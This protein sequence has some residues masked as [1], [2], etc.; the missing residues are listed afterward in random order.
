[1]NEILISYIFT[2]LPMIDITKARNDLIFL[3]FLRPSLPAQSTGGFI[4]AL[5]CGTMNIQSTVLS[6]L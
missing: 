3:R 2:L 4:S 6:F 1:M 5:V